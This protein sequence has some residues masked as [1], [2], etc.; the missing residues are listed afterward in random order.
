VPGIEKLHALKDSLGVIVRA[1]L[2]IGVDGRNRP[3]LYPQ[4]LSQEG[5]ELAN[6]ILY[7]IADQ[8]PAHEARI[9]RNIADSCSG[10]PDSR[11][12]LALID[13]GAA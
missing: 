9:L 2:P 8:S 11:P 7:S 12:Q 1:K 4:G 13:G 3:S 6:D 10:V 5:V